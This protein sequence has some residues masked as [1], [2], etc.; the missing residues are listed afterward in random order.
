MRNGGRYLGPPQA[1]VSE[2]IADSCIA[3][4]HTVIG[5]SLALPAR[6]RYNTS[7]RER[8]LLYG[9]FCPVHLWPDLRCPPRTVHRTENQPDQTGA[10]RRKNEVR[11]SSVPGDWN[12]IGYDPPQRLHRPPD[13][14]DRAEVR[15]LLGGQPQDILYQKALFTRICTPPCSDAASGKKG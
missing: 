10:D 5:A 3:S 13:D 1:T 7:G 2:M 14:R 6:T 4:A 15:R 8:S 9:R 12:G 11:L